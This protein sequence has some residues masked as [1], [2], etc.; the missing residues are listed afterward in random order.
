MPE[1]RGPRGGIDMTDAAEKD[2]ANRASGSNISGSS[3]ASTN[4]DS[5]EVAGIGSQQ[6]SDAAARSTGTDATSGNRN[7][8]TSD[9]QST[10]GRAAD[11][12]GEAIGNAADATGDAIT[13]GVGKARDAVTGNL[14]SNREEGRNKATVMIPASHGLPAINVPL[15]HELPDSWRIDIPDTVDAA[16]L[17]ANLQKHLTKAHEMKDQWPADANEAYLAVSHHVLLAIFEGTPAVQQ[18]STGD[19][20]QPA[21]GTI[22]PTAPRTTPPGAAQ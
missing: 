8:G 13:A 7:V 5:A 19:S 14:D 6:P 20:A 2:L 16:T 17:R 11:R 12:T 3:N 21:A 10:L 1:K 22:S 15:I 9:D 4:S 18:G